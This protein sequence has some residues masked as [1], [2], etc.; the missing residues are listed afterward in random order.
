MTIGQ[1]YLTHA[2]HGHV[3][4]KPAPG[5]ILRRALSHE[6]IQLQKAVAFNIF[7]SIMTVQLQPSH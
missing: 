4:L 1:L 7:S 5:T 3:P 6:D 2:I